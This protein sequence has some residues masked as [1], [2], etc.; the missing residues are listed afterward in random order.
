ME[1]LRDH[2]TFECRQLAP[3]EHPVPSA[4]EIQSVVLAGDGGGF[5][6]VDDPPAIQQHRTVAEPLDRHPFR[7]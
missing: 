2:W 7:G 4:V 6:E 1:N 5:A 3:L